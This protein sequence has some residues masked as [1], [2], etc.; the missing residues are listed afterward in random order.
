[1]AP[2]IPPHLLTEFFHNMDYFKF[3]N[4]APSHLCHP[5]P[6]GVGKKRRRRKRG[7]GWR[8]FLTGTLL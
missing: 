7:L 4:M 5:H 6:L 3:H 1:M 8:T 2:K